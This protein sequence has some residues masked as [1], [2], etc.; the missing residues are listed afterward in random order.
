MT[1]TVLRSTNWAITGHTDIWQP[2]AWY[3]LVGKHIEVINSNKPT[4]PNICSLSLQFANIRN[5]WIICNV[6]FTFIWYDLVLCNSR[7]NA[8]INADKKLLENPG[9]DPGTSHMLSERSTIWANPPTA[10]NIQQCATN[11]DNR[12]RD[13]DYQWCITVL[14]MNVN[15]TMPINF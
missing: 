11:M 3:W 8:V 7:R 9:I 6:L 10:Q 15:Q 4:W 2:L 13:S 1:T 5:F 12:P 14:T